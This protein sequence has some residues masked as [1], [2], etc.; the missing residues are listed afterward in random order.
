[1]GM[2]AAMRQI[3]GIPRPPQEILTTVPMAAAALKTEAMTKTGKM[4]GL[5]SG[6]SF[7][8]ERDPSAHSAGKRR[9]RVQAESARAFAISGVRSYWSARDSSTLEVL[10]RDVKLLT[11]S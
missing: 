8:A 11:S 7:F 1:M 10:S 9:A 6:R 3:K 5:S 2:K 4:T